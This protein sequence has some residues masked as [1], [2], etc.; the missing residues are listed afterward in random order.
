MVDVDLDSCKSTQVI[1]VT[2]DYCGVNFSR[3]KH[4]IVFLRRFTP[5]DSCGSKECT[6]LKR[7]ESTNS[8][9]GE[10]CFKGKLLDKARASNLKKYGVKNPM[11]LEDFKDKIKTTNLKKYGKSSYLATKECKEKA[12]KKA[13]ELYGVDHF[14]RS[15]EL[16]IKSKETSI[17]RYGDLFQKTKRW[18]DKVKKVCIERYGVES[19]SMS[20]EF[21]AKKEKTMMEKYGG[22]SALCHPEFKEKA[23]RTLM[24]NYG[25]E[26]ALQSPAIMKKMK[27]TCMERYGS[28]HAMSNSEIKTKSIQTK[29]DK[30]GTL[31]P[32]TGKTQT[33]V[34]KWL[35]SMGFK[36][37]NDVSIL[38]GKELDLYD[39]SQKLAIEYCGLYWHNENSLSP[40]CRSYHHFK[41]KRCKEKGIQLLTI[42]DDEWN[43]RNE[44][45]RSLILSK[46]GM[47]QEKIQARKCKVKQISKKEMAEFCEKYHLQGA[48]KLSKVCFGLFHNDG[49]V[50]VMDLGRHHRRKEKDA[51]VLTR[52]CFKS[53][54]Q[55][56]GGSGKLFKACVDWCNENGIC[57]I[58]SWSDNRY[59]DGTV[60]EKLGFER[61]EDLP[62]DYQY[63]DMKN[64]KRRIS[65]QSQ[66]KKQSQ[67]PENMTELE[68]A[69]S[70][71]LSRIWDCG[72][73]RWE[74]SIQ[75][76]CQG[77]PQSV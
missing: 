18:K 1:E 23:K 13:L 43:Y 30:Y 64:P 47:F 38:E 77:T 22:K 6:V 10:G 41:W 61:K 67:C 7:A 16:K 57:K 69:N 8:I 26:S 4:H 76:Q 71:S 37:T 70:R 35:N 73:V 17:R 53:D 14:S 66:S 15:E 59:S 31:I 74:F 65:K 48:N 9:H 20:D 56:V 36:F 52:L 44:V 58:V 63:V 54:T 68:W 42:F 34:T 2:C 25:V 33:E 32:K 60:Y 5:K 19:V 11:E 50:G 29:L 45:C 62:P 3:K 27:K 40:R 12:K 72:K 28:E 24:K 39:P 21:K 55:V 49:L 75:P 51:V 46:L